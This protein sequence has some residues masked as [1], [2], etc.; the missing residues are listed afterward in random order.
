MLE[1]FE[2][3]AKAI[4]DPTRIRILKI[5]EPGELCVCQVTAVLDLAP[6]T[7]SK[8]LAVLKTAGLVQMRRAGK[9]AHYRLAERAFN[10]YAADFLAMARSTLDD[11]PTIA[12]DRRIL[13]QVNAAPI[14]AVCDLGRAAIDSSAA[15]APSQV[16]LNPSCCGAPQ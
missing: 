12:E 6:A 8:H 13:A 1:T 2:T 3:V 5:L 16:S 14:Q 15:V 10:P 7:I 4:A 11:D 9:W